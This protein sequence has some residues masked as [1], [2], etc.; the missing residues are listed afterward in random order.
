MGNTNRVKQTDPLNNP[1]RE[2]LTLDQLNRGMVLSDK[3]EAVKNGDSAENKALKAKLER[4][5]VKQSDGSF[6]YGS[7][8]LDSTGLH[9]DNQISENDFIDFADKLVAFYNR[10]QLWLGDMVLM[11]RKFYPN[12]RIE[13][14]AHHYNLD[15][16]TIDEYAIICD[17]VPMSMRHPELSF[18]HYR[19]VRGKRYDD[20][21]PTLLQYAAA[22]QLTVTGFHEYLQGKE[23]EET[24]AEY[25]GRVGAGK[26]KAFED[27]IMELF[28][29][30][31]RHDQHLW[32]GRLEKLI[33]Q[34]RQSMG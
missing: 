25:I 15:P 3:R 7:I 16:K 6:V 10:M 8:R 27:G 12:V 30:I 34:M 28:P 4:A 21:R 29:S 19:L 24:D 13:D 23:P 11:A 14:I 22:N 20:D 18:S 1:G 32:I 33:K 26:I 9:Y 17:I 2:T 5:F 31:T